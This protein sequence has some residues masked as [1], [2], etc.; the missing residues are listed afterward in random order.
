MV[1][2]PEHTKHPGFYDLAN[3]KPEHSKTLLKMQ[4][5]HSNTLA[6]Y[7][8][9]RNGGDIS[10]LH[11]LYQYVDDSEPFNSPLRSGH[12]PTKEANDLNDLL[13]KH[14]NTDPVTVFR[15]ITGNSEDYEPNEIYKKRAFTSTSLDPGT[16]SYFARDEKHQPSFMQ[17]RVPAGHPGYYVGDEDTGEAEHILPPKTH[18]KIHHVEDIDLPQ[19]LHGLHQTP[20]RVRHILAEVIPHHEE[21]KNVIESKL[22]LLA[23]ELK[24]SRLSSLKKFG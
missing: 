2:L 5:H 9:K 1:K 4:Y 23:S 10:H 12:A 22:R 7:Q 24:P 8:H 13:H 11:P 21:P 3:F 17:I 18:L 14:H 20:H 6:N 19:H 15:G 16:A